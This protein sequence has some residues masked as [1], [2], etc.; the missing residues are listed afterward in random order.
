VRSDPNAPDYPLDGRKAAAGAKELVAVLARAGT[1]PPKPEELIDCVRRHPLAHGAITHRR[2]AFQRLR[3]T[4]ALYFRLFCPWPDWSFVAASYTTATGVSFDLVWMS[5]G[6]RYIVDSLITDRRKVP[7]SD[8]ERMA[9]EL[10]RAAVDEFGD[11]ALGA[12]LCCFGRPAVSR[13]G[14]PDGS[15][16]PLGE[17]VLA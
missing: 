10:A 3:S 2:G 13:F 4:V 9:S 15:V 16:I 1:W 5:A 6:G 7:E 8:A 12:R 11:E 17:A 14:H